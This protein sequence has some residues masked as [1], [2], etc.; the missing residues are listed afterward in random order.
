MGKSIKNLSSVTIIGLDIAKNVFQVTVHFTCRF[1]IPR[2][3]LRAALARPDKAA[4]NAR[5]IE[6][7]SIKCTVSVI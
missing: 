7:R 2:A 5:P 3:R 4:D 1:A 6:L